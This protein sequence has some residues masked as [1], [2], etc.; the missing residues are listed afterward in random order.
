MI[1]IASLI[2]GLG[3]TL[4]S[5]AGAAPNIVFILVDDMGYGDLSSYGAPDAKTPHI[6]QLAAEGVRL[7]QCYSNGAECTPS[8]T[9]ILTGRYPQRVGGLECAIGTGNVGR[10]DHA[11]NLA[12]KSDLGLPADYAVLVPG[13]KKAGYATA[14]FGKWHLGYEPKFN[15]LEQGFDEFRGFLGGNVDYF[16]HVE[17]SDLPVILDGRE[18]VERK[19]YMTHVITNDAIEFINEQSKDK[20]SPFFLYVPYSTPHF[21]FQGPRDAGQELWPAEQWTVGE[22]DKYVEMLEDMDDEVGRLMAALAAAGVDDNTL[23]V[24]ASDHG[25]MKPGVNTPFRDYKGTLFEGG[26]RVPCIARWPG[27]L[28]EGLVSN[29]VTTLMDLT[30]SFLRAAGAEIPD[31]LDGMDIIEHIQ[32]NRADETRNLFW[33]ARRGDRTWVAARMG[34]HKYVKKTEG[35]EAEEWFFDLK[36]DHREEKSLLDSGGESLANAKSAL[37]N[38]EKAVTPE[39]GQ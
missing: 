27:K 9:A 22:R 29:Q 32:E 8:R 2:V 4:T 35:G 33:R 31:D 20:D 18:F 38:W 12:E 30:P 25:A 17:L 11:I 24:Y 26:I 16:H 5:I 14:V 37:A 15:P 21:P 1:R 34:E 28:K 3:L 13:L 19:G 10:Y 6:D 7:T 36:E 39:R 23:V